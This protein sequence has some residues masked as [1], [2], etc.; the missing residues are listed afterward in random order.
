[1][2]AVI[3]LV[4]GMLGLYGVLA[5]WV[6]LGSR[7]TAIRVA[8]GAR[9][10]LV[11]G[12]VVRRALALCGVGICTGVLLYAP[13]MPWLSTLLFGVS[14]GDPLTLLGAT[15]ALTICTLVASSLPALRAAHIDPITALQAQ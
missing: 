4:L 3:T 14:T 9:P 10:D 15:F 8:L 1:M 12:A 5:Y 13:A 6:A 11:A 2:A 7:E